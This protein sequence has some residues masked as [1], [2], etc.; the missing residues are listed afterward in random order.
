MSTR[1]KWVAAHAPSRANGPGRLAL[2]WRRR[3][4]ERCPGSRPAGPPPRFPP[5]LAVS[6]DRFLGSLSWDASFDQTGTRTWD[7]GAYARI[8]RGV[9]RTIT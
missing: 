8:P 5:T 2:D 1:R 3:L 4:H 7:G 6:R 9:S